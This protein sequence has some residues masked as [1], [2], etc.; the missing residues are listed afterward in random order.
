MSVHRSVLLSVHLYHV[1]KNRL[2]CGL[3]VVKALEKA[4]LAY[5]YTAPCAHAQRLLRLLQM[6]LV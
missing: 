5:V 1:C 2:I 4:S 3:N 6:S